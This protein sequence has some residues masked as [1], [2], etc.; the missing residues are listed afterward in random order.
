MTTTTQPDARPW[1][2]PSSD[3]TPL[4]EDEREQDAKV[5]R[6]LRARDRAERKR[7]GKAGNRANRRARLAQ[8]RHDRQERRDQHYHQRA[9]SAR[10]RV[11]NPDR[12]LTSAWRAYTLFSIGTAAVILAALVWCSVTVG[13]A[14]NMGFEGYMVESLF[15][16]LL[17]ISLGAQMY[18]T[19]HGRTMPRGHRAID[20]FLLAASLALNIVPWGVNT[21][22]SEMARLPAHALPPLVLV[23]AVFMQYVLSRVFISILLEAD[24]AVTTHHRAEDSQQPDHITDEPDQHPDQSLDHPDQL[25][26]HQA[27]DATTAASAEGPDPGTTSDWSGRGTDEPDHG[28]APLDHQADHGQANPDESAKTQ[29]IAWSSEH[30]QP[31]SDHAGT[32]ANRTAPTTAGTQSPRRGQEWSSTRLTIPDHPASPDSAWSSSASSGPQ[33]E[34]QPT[35]VLPAIRVEPDDDEDEERSALATRGMNPEDIAELLAPVAEALIAEDDFISRTDVTTYTDVNSS[36]TASKIQQLLKDRYP[37]HPEPTGRRKPERTRT[38]TQAIADI[39]AQPR[40][41]TVR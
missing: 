38:I 22:W 41:Q 16:V 3:E 7:A 35:G 14:L 25:L 23:A 13:Q 17:V 33:P 30:N 40:L 26:D 1:S 4:A 27:T 8:Q 19:R 24:R 31:H 36:G 11:T 20:V 18:A 6:S 21:N 37:D 12:R 5:D 2:P 34:Q 10:L 28:Q 15:S 9:L 39:T 29:G 32:V